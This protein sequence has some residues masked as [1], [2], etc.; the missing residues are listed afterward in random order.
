MRKLIEQV[1]QSEYGII[2]INI[3]DNKDIIKELEKITKNNNVKVVNLK[4]TR[5]KIF[6]VNYTVKEGQIT[7]E[8]FSSILR[9]RSECLWSIYKIWDC[10]GFNKAKMTDPYSSKIFMTFLK[11]FYTE[12]KTM[13]I[14]IKEQFL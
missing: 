3:D 11:Q 6:K 12:E 5:I 4:N 13:F 8:D 10:M 14:V 7:K 1:N 2:A 9:T